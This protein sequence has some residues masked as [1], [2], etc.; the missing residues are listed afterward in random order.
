VL[1]HG[2]EDTVTGGGRAGVGLKRHKEESGSS[3]RLV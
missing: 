2:D 3:A 1:S